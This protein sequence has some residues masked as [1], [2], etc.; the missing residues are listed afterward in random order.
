MR[1]DGRVGAY[2]EEDDVWTIGYGTTFY[3]NGKKVQPNDVITVE[4]AIKYLELHTQKVARDLTQVLAGVE[5]NQNQ[6]D[7]LVDFTYN[8]GIGNFTTSVLC[9]LIKANP[10]DPAIFDQFQ[11]WVFRA[12]KKLPGLVIRRK[13]DA[14]LYFA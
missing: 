4:D 3:P 9:K 5:L 6:F 11:R 13:K 2:L 8:L 1:A 12:K 14:D 10:C 7:A